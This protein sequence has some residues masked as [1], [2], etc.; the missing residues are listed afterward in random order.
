MNIV[1]LTAYYGEEECLA[2]TANTIL[3]QLSEG[4]LW[5]IVLDNIS[6]DL[7]F[8]CDGR[9]SI[10]KYQG[11]PGAGNARNFG[12]NYLKNSSID[13]P[14]ALW[15]I[16]GDDQLKNGAVRRVREVIQQNDDRVFTFSYEIVTP[17]ARQIINTK[18]GYFSV[19]DLL[20]NYCT[21]C[22]CTIVKV[23]D[24]S[25]FD[26]VKF[27][28]R[29]RANDQLFFLNA[30]RF[31]GRGM[32]VSE[33]ILE[34]NVGFNRTLSSNKLKMPYYKFLALRD[35]GLNFPVTLY[36]FSVYIYRNLIKYVKIYNSNN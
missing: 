20:Y 2:R 32:F 33:I 5:I 36:F 23:S 29:R 6:L 21:P 35:F 15:P 7:P 11:A 19:I 34:Y 18:K 9:V 26:Q 4:D 16:D 3:P 14:L 12:L 10:L 30:C 28:F 17:S 1:L 27:G 22:G 24:R 31:H 8:E 25:F 13:Y